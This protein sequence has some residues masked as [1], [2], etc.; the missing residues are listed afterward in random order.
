MQVRPPEILLQWLAV[1]NG[2]CIG[3]GGLFG[4]ATSRTD[5]DIERVLRLY[6]QWATKNWIPVAGDGCGNY[7]VLL[8]DEAGAPVGFIDPMHDAHSIDMLVASGLRPFVE[9]L[10]RKE[11]GEA[12]GWP[13]SRDAASRFDPDLLSLESE[14]P[15]AFER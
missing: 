13:F 10:L 1:S 12:E 2:P 9:L 15:F 8:A 5:L 4:V 6:P 7:Y 11:L 14:W 3:P